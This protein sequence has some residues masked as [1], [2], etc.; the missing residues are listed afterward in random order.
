MHLHAVER[1][2]REHE[3]DRV[4]E[5][6]AR[7]GDQDWRERRE[8]RRDQ[9]RA[10]ARALA[11][12]EREPYAHRIGGDV[13]RAREH[14]HRR[15][16]HAHRQLVVR[17]AVERA[18]PGAGQRVRALER[19]VE[20]E[21]ERRVEE[22]MRVPVDAPAAV[23]PHGER[24]AER[25]RLLDELRQPVRDPRR[26]QRHRQRDDRSGGR[27][28][29]PPRESQAAAFLPNDSSIFNRVATR[30][31]GMVA[32]IT[33]RKKCLYPMW[34]WS[35]PLHMPGNIMPMAMKPVQMA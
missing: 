6:G 18:G 15:G 16:I 28:G 14:H 29:E 20:V 24:P 13:E 25:R 11:D 22:V 31:L 2:E 27:G 23:R 4:G 7:G 30:K 32:R 19:E 3:H 21:R 26:P 34:S 8:E 12:P 17:G 1:G 35:Q 33:T 5:D 9:A 10:G